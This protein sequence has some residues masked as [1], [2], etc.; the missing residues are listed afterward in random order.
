MYGNNGISLQSEETPFTPASPY[1]I[2][3]LYAHWI[4]NI[5]RQSYDMFA[6]TGILFNHESPLRGLEFVSRKITN[7]VAEIHL[8]LKDEL[9]LG[10]LE[11]ER[12]WG[13]APEY[14]EAMHL[15]LQES[16]PVSLVVST[17]ESHMVSEF[18]KLAFEL[19]GLNWKKYVKTDKRFFRPLDVDHL[20]GDYGK[21]KKLISWQPRI[22]FDHLVKVMLEEDIRRWKMFIAGKSFPWDAPLYPSES[23]IITRLSRENKKAE[24]SHKGY[25]NGRAKRSLT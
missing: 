20:C 10:N 13:Y 23:N 3:K 9:V 6:V 16:R 2:S 5:Y 14:V 22:K 21:A 15:M 25:R 18:V 19:V 12:D 24:R 8:G 7:G 17:G 1:A 11:A 4:T